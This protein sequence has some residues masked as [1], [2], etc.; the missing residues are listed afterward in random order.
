M[1]DLDALTFEDLGL[2]DLPLRE[3][4]GKYIDAQ[5]NL[6]FIE[7]WMDLVLEEILERGG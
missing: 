3:L 4:K 5:R 6:Q 1:D 7:K 2:D